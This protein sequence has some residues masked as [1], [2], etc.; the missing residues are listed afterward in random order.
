MRMDLQYSQTV[1][2]LLDQRNT[3]FAPQFGH[4]PVG[5]VIERR[6]RTAEVRPAIEL[7]SRQARLPEH[8]AA[9]RVAR[10]SKLRRKVSA[11]DPQSP[12]PAA[13]HSRTD[14]GKVI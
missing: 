13:A 12:T 1:C 3:I 2:T 5:C 10:W 8:T 7:C 4:V 14:S 9:P 11:D 6:S